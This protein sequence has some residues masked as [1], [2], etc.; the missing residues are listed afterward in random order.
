[1]SEDPEKAK[2]DFL[3]ALE[4]QVRSLPGVESVERIVDDF[5]LR[6]VLTGATTILT[7]Y[8][9]NLW[10]E[11]RTLPPEGRDV[12]IQR[13]LQT[14][15][16]DRPEPPADRD[17]L[18]ARLRPV[19]RD[20]GTL[21]SPVGSELV[22]RP[23][24]PFLAEVLVVDSEHAMTFLVGSELER[25]GV[26]AEE[27]FAR[28]RQNLAAL[29]PDLELGAD[30]ANPGVIRCQVGDEYESSRLLLGDWLQAAADRSATRLL[31]AA[32]E[33]GSLILFPERDVRSTAH[34][35]LAV[36]KHFENA[37]RSVSP[38][39][40]SLDGRGHV[41][42]YR[43]GADHPGL[44]MLELGHKKLALVSY[45]AQAERLCA[46]LPP[47]L[48]GARVLPFRVSQPDGN[49]PAFS[50]CE[51]SGNQPVLMPLTEFVRVSTVTR[52]LRRPLEVWVRGAELRSQLGRESRTIPELDPELVLIPRGPGPQDA[53]WLRRCAIPATS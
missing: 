30:D 18:L 31:V 28:A 24:L 34:F 5:A 9:Q 53:G 14:L 29:T 4:R 39:V 26:S 45:Q 21:R 49:R 22:H 48:A 27:A 19:L 6:V 3:R 35:A 36:Q 42:P 38:A 43:P 7:F 44:A 41:V 13:F 12:E 11:V 2:R 1:M 50:W 52:W 20:R 33:R 10:D 16:A 32:P 51:W 37:T 40:Y 15:F 23:A 46:E 8:A 17:A 25:Y 47:A